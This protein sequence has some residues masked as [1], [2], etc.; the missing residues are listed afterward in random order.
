MRTKVTAC[1]WAAL[2]TLFL[3]WVQP[4]SSADSEAIRY[5]DLIRTRYEALKSFSA[6]FE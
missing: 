2:S 3:P 5:A 1:A 6:D 4:A